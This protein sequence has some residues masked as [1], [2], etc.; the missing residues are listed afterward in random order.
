MD[1]ITAE[2]RADQAEAWAQ[3]GKGDSMVTALVGNLLQRSA[4]ESDRIQNQLQTAQEARI[5]QLEREVAFLRPYAESCWAI[6]K[7]LGLPVY[8]DE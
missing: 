1:K 6:R 5:E 3:L 8:F 4:E 7:A 2:E